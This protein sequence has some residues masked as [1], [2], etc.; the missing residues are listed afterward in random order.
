LVEVWK[1]FDLER[2]IYGGILWK[3]SLGGAES[4]WKITDQV[5]DSNKIDKISIGRWQARL[6]ILSSFKADCQ[7]RRKIAS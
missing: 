2:W 7:V 3:R 6:A 1:H 4:G 5:S